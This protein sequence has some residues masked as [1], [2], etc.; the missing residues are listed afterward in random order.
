M[1]AYLGL[2]A[3]TWVGGVGAWGVGVGYALGAARDRIGAPPPRGPRMAINGEDGDA[4]TPPVETIDVDSLPAP[5]LPLDAPEAGGDGRRMRSAAPDAMPTFDSLDDMDAFLL[6]QEARMQERPSL[7]TIS[8]EDSDDPD[9]SP[10]ASSR[11]QSPVA[12]R[13]AAASE[14]QLRPPDASA[15]LSE[16]QRRRLA[17]IKPLKRE[18]R[19]RKI[20]APVIQDEKFVPL[21]PG[22]RQSQEEVILNAYNGETLDVKREQGEDFWVDPELVQE[23]V[24]NKEKKAR[25]LEKFKTSEESFG[26]ERLKKEIAAPYKNNVIGV[27]VVGVGVVSVLFAL[28]PGLLELSEPPSIASFP[29]NL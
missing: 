7:D 29:L 2:A 12:T 28:F 15:L 16:S 22:A 9:V 6:R 23:Q 17:P 4:P 24:R 1:A 18:R 26:Q 10:M 5:P 13:A 27:I 20:R 21:V 14:I 3:L 25:R 8:E 11:S 19:S